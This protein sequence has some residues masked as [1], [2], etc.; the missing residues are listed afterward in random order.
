MPLSRRGGTTTRHEDSRR[1]LELLDAAG[2]GGCEERAFGLLSEGERQQV[3]LARALMSEPELLLLDE[4][5]AGLDLAARER[6]ILQARRPR[7]GRFDAADG[8]RDASHR[9][10]PA[11]HNPCRPDAGSQGRKERDRSRQVLT[12]DDLS[13]CFGVRVH[14]EMVGNRWFAQSTG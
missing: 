8:A 2:L 10:D 14:L 6:L 13:A 7:C 3:L 11:R 5:A 4:P 12:D 1:A 9:R